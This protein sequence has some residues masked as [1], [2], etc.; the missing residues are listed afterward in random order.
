V[1]G[2]PGVR[3]DDVHLTERPHRRGEIGDRRLVDHAARQGFRD[4]PAPV[5][6]PTVSASVL[7]SRAVA[8]TR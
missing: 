8:A 6:A 3:D 7:L 4:P 5:T 1:R 2:D